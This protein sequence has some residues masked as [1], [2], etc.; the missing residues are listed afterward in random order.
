LRAFL[1][2]FLQR[3]SSSVD[4]A[5]ELGVN[6]GDDPSVLVPTPV[7]GGV[8]GSTPATRGGVSGS[9]TKPGVLGP[10]VGHENAS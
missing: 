7:K 4:V 6:G 3:H 9:P 2:G 5:V 10:G 1:R 8:N